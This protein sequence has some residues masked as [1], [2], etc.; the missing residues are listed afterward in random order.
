MSAG[1]PLMGRPSSALAFR[2][3]IRFPAFPIPL[4]LARVSLT[5]ARLPASQNQLLAGPRSKEH[6][7]LRGLQCNDCAIF[8][9]L[10]A[11]FALIFFWTF[12]ELRDHH[13]MFGLIKL[14]KSVE[15][16]P[17]GIVCATRTVCG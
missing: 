13:I 16:G 1:D 9:L 6:Q 12:S 10:C 11:D 14:V 7:A 4:T 17:T 2:A 5:D 3:P 8:T 15:H